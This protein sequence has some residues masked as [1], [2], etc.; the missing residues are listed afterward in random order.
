MD[1]RD[2]LPT[3]EVGFGVEDAWL[4]VVVGV[5]DSVVLVGLFFADVV[6]DVV[7]DVEGVV[8]DDSVGTGASLTCAGPKIL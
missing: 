2:G 7:A 4:V 5:L 1:D 3:D 6:A 8:E